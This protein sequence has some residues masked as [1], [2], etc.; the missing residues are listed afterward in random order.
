M[1][2][3]QLPGKGTIAAILGVIVAIAFVGLVLMGGQVTTILSNV[4][5]SIGVPNVGSGVDTTARG[6]TG[7]AD[8][9]ATGDVDGKEDPI[10]DPAVATELLIIRTGQLTIEV[11]DLD[12]AVTQ[13]TAKIDAVGGFVSGSDRTSDGE[14]AAAS[15]TFRIPADRWDDALAA[16]QGLGTATRNLHVETEAVTNQVIDLGAR[17]TNLRATEAALQKIMDQATKIPD[18]LDVQGK[19]TEVRGEI[20]QLVAQ[21]AHLEEQAAF[22]TLTVTFVLPV[23]PVVE[24]VKAGWDPAAD[25]DAAT[26]ALIGLGQRLASFGIWIAIVGVPIAIGLGILLAFAFVAWRLGRRGRADAVEP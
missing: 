2:S 11:G 3:E 26:G 22:G 9:P 17:I 18:V 7:T 12:A 6:A 23:P 13:A 21:K 10:V 15:A 19:L 4:G 16:V 5:N 24:E 25:A 20:E 14:A 1:D 8:Q